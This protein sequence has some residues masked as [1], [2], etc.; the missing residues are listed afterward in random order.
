MASFT[1]RTIDDWHRLV[2][3]VRQ[4]AGPL[5]SRGTPLR[6]TVAEKRAGRRLEQNAF[7]WAGVLDQIAQ[8][9]CIGGRWFSAE[10]IHEH[11]KKLHLPERCAKG[12]EKWAYHADGTRSLQMGTSDLDDAEFDLY[13]L[14]IQGHAASEWGVAFTNQQDGAQPR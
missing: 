6:V 2:E 12:V 13:L 14:A 5:A 11:L 4:H 8:Q 10:T 1:L 7:M 3:V 9:L